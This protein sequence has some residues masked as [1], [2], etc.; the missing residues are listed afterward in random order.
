MVFNYFNQKAILRVKN[1]TPDTLE[2]IY[3]LPRSSYRQSLK[4]EISVT[5]AL[6]QVEHIEYVN[7]VA[8]D[9]DISS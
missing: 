1:T 5:D 6:Y 3:E 7:V 8:Q 2:L 9:D 4:K